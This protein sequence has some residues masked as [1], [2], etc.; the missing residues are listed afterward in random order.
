MGGRVDGRGDL[1][2]EEWERLEPFL[3]VSN[4][5]CGRWHDHRQVIDGVSFRERT[6]VPWRDLPER[7]G[8]WK[9]VYERHPRGSADRTWDEL[10]VRVQA[11]ARSASAR[12]RRGW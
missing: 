8:P 11:L 1:S 7:F 5:R 3:P 2:D 10:L 9:T 6:G 12:W 4:D